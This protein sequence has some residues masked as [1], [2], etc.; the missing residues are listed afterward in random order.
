[1]PACKDCNS[2]KGHKTTA[3]LVLDRLA[4]EKSDIEKSETNQQAV[5]ENEKKLSEDSSQER[6][7]GD[8]GPENGP[9]DDSEKG[10]KKG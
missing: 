9:E 7:D 10:S 4:L 8:D 3:E 1:V 2:K 6:M 5:E